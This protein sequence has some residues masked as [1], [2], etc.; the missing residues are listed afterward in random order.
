MQHSVE[1]KLEEIKMT[2]GKIQKD[3]SKLKI[4]CKPNQIKSTAN[5]DF[6]KNCK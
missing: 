2:N 1:F 4:K 3:I 6:E 5:H